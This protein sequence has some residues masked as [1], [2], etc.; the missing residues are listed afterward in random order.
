MLVTKTQKMSL[1]RNENT[2]Q[3]QPWQCL[4]IGTWNVLS[5]YSPGASNVLNQEVERVKNKAYKIC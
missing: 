4:R 3:R 2:E 1:G 5:F